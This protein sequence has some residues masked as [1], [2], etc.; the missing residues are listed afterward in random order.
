M[1]EATSVE[2]FEEHR[3]LLVSITYRMLGSLAEA[4]DVVQEAWLRW[5]RTDRSE[6]ANVR[7]FLVRMTTRLAID[8]LRRLKA[9]RES[10][11][12]PWLPEPV[13]TER[14]GRA[15]GPWLRCGR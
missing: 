11:I 10:Y 2:A 5:D 12:G 15:G 3:S 4:E 8:R 7:A 1:S 6:I 9:R 14:D 13:L